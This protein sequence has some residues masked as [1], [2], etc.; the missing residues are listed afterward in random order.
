MH[1]WE[2]LGVV[3]LERM[4]VAHEGAA[5]DLGGYSE[6]ALRRIDDCLLADHFPPEADVARAISIYL[7]DYLI[8]VIQGAHWLLEPEGWIWLALPT[9]HRL[10]PYRGVETALVKREPIA[11]RFVM[12][13]SELAS[14]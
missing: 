14:R 12:T 13:A 7:C 10:D 8:G 4:S 5:A 1:V 3:P 6:T 2:R 9:K 11:Q